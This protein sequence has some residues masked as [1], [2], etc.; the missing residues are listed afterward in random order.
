MFLPDAS[1]K[2]LER[3]HGKKDITHIASDFAWDGMQKELS[4]LF[5]SGSD[6]V[7]GSELIATLGL[8]PDC[9]EKEPY[10]THLCLRTHED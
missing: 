2:A 6:A 10:H 1:I 3:L 4:N 5:K 8:C 9:G 7:Q